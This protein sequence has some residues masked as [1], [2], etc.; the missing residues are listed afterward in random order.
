MITQ[1]KEIKEEARNFLQDL[2]SKPNHPSLSVDSSLLQNI[3][4]LISDEEN[5]GFKSPI[6]EA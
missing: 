4:S 1:S 6:L 2:H 5:Y 3:P